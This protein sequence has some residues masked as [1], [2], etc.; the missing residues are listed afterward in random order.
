MA[1]LRP[2]SPVGTA[3]WQYVLPR[4]SKAK[5]IDPC[6]AFVAQVELMAADMSAV[7]KTWMGPKAVVL[8]DDAR[9]CRDVPDGWSDLVLTSPPYANNYDYADATRLEMCFFGEIQGWGD[10]QAAV[11]DRLVRACTQHVAPYAQQAE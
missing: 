4:K 7:Q 2:C 9:R 10:L 5:S 6:D 8:E 3:Q 1:I 11:R